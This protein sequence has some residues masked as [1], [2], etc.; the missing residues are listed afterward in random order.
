MNSRILYFVSI[1]TRILPESRCFG[2]KRVLYKWAGID[3]GSNV[4]ICSSALILGSGK[5]SIGNNTWIGPQ[6]LISASASINIG[7]DVNIAPR[8]SLI[9]GSHKIDFEGPSIA[10][11][12]ISE[13]IIVKDGAWICANSTILGSSVIGK[14]SIVAAGAV[15]KG[16]YDDNQL[17]T[18]VLARQRPQIKC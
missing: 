18:G 9:C 16:K 1:F 8:V 5:L 4:R 15:T 2:I 6:S 12:G 3:I 10:G 11:E 7:S 17:I 13:D 14:K